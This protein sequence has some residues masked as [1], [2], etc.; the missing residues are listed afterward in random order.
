ML[1]AN[2]AGSLHGAAPSAVRAG[3]SH[4]SGVAADFIV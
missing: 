4:G 2:R 3:D 1:A